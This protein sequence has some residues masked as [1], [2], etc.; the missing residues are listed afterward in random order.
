M[1]GNIEWFKSFP[2][3]RFAASAY[4]VCGRMILR[5]RGLAAKSCHVPR[6][7]DDEVH[8]CR[9]SCCDICL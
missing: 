9:F 1:N 7:W 4:P 2:V 6:L 3:F 8:R 5:G